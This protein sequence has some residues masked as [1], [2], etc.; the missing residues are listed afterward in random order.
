MTEQADLPKQFERRH[1]LAFGRN[2]ISI[3]DIAPRHRR[4]APLALVSGWASTAAVLK[5]NILALA[6]TGR[7]VIYVEAPHGID[8]EARSGYPSTALRKAA[9]LLL[10]LDERRVRSADVVAHSEG[11]IVA[12]VAA[13]LS[14]GRIRNLVLVN[15]AGLSGRKEFSR[16]AQDFSADT[17]WDE[18]RRMLSDPSLARTVLTAWLEAG[19]AI[20]ADPWKSYE[21]A[22]AISAADIVGLLDGL[23]RKGT[24]VAIIHA[25]GDKAFPVKDLCRR[26]RRCPSCRV[27]IVPGSHLEFYH[28]PIEFAERIDKALRSLAPHHLKPRATGH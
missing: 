25:S 28:K 5:G 24:G 21:E 2:R 4:G 3:V 9:A 16:L 18:M 26:I 15:P 8:A 22:K 14:P 13:T 23:R 12:A 6:G 11:A 17:L 27:Q 7:R 20:A 1:I 19:R 10:A